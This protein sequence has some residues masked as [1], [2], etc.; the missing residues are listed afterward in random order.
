MLQLSSLK[1]H[2]D[3]IKGDMKK[4]FAKLTDDDLKY[5]EGEEEELL[6]RLEKKL[7]VKREELEKV[8]KEHLEKSKVK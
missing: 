2:W 3:Q 6:G 5:V 8:M 1:G 7:G 4:K